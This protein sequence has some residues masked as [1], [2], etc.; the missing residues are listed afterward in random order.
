[1]NYNIKTR[2]INKPL[3][4]KLILKMENGLV[5]FYKIGLNILIWETFVFLS[6]SAWGHRVVERQGGEDQTGRR[7]GGGSRFIFFS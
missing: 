7:R 3:L 2:V 6:P 5:F 4:L 1:M